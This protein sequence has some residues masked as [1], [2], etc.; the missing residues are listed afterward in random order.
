MNLSLRNKHF[1]F[2]VFKSCSQ[3]R[4]ILQP[5]LR[6]VLSTILSRFLFLRNLS[7]QNVLLV[8]GLDPCFGQPCQK[9][10]S[11]KTATRLLGKTKSGFPN[12]RCRRR[13]PV[14]P[15]ARSIRMS[16]S[17]VAL[18]PW[19]RILDIT[20]DRFAFVKTSAI[21]PQKDNSPKFAASSNRL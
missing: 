11:T 7:V 8:F 17:S 13:Q 4:T 16:A 5:L 10:P 9:Q 12:T 3:I 21:R 14:M 6:K 15:F 2:M 1:S 18:L 20:S 19:P